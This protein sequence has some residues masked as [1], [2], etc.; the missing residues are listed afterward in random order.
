MKRAAAETPTP[1]RKSPRKVPS[2]S[3][4]RKS[5][6]K[7]PSSAEK[8][9]LK[10]S[11]EEANKQKQQKKKT[12]WRKPNKELNEE[13]YVPIMKVMVA[14]FHLLEVCFYLK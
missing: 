13:I 10:N 7:T 2:D 4:T 6:R 11:K 5:P 12:A 8:K 14:N 1:T 3:P 9:A